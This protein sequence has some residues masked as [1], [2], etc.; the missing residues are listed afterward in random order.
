MR[1]KNHAKAI[2]ARLHARD[3]AL[4]AG[5]VYQGGGGVEIGE[6]GHH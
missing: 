4:H 2:H 6:R 1:A 5:S 3:V